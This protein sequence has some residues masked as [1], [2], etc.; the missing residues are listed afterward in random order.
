MQRIESEGETGEISEMEKSSQG[1]LLPFAPIM[2]KRPSDSSCHQP[3]SRLAR[4]GC[5]VL[6]HDDLTQQRAPLIDAG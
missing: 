2:V 6:R 1:Q 3:C 5:G 4:G